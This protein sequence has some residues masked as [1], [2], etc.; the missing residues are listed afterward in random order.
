MLS[1][2]KVHTCLI[3]HN[4]NQYVHYKSYKFGNNINNTRGNH[5][6]LKT[7]YEIIIAV[8]LIF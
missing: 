7:F 1:K 6:I 8:S 4:R 2:K 5:V 3:S